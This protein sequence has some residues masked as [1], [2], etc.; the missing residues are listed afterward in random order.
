MQVTFLDLPGEIRNKIY[1][2]VLPC[3]TNRPEPTILLA[4]KQIRAECLTLY[5]SPH[6]FWYNNS[7][8]PWKY[9]SFS[10]S[11]ACSYLRH[12]RLAWFCKYTDIHFGGAIHAHLKDNHIDFDFATEATKRYGFPF[13][14]H[15]VFQRLNK[16]AKERFKN[17]KKLTGNDLFAAVDMLGKGFKETPFKDLSLALDKRITYGKLSK[18]GWK[19]EFRFELALR[20]ICSGSKA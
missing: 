18:E 17:K 2:L 19:T 12:I 10:S 9:Y 1:D 5:Y 16:W 4:N 3:G 14:Y 13:S 20:P 8:N 15:C 11:D 6:A 7:I